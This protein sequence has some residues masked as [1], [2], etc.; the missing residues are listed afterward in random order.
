MASSINFEVNSV[1]LL[2]SN[3]NFFDR[4][5]I[6]FQCF[7]KHKS[8][9]EEIQIHKIKTGDTILLSDATFAQQY[10]GYFYHKSLRAENKTV[11]ILY[12]DS[13][14]SAKNIS[15]I[16]DGEGVRVV[17]IDVSSKSQVESR[18]LEC[19]V[20]ENTQD[21]FSLTAEELAHFFKCILIKG[22]GRVSDIVIELNKREGE[23]E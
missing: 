12:T 11:Q 3:A 2:L 17:D 8:D 22:K 14:T 16:I 20:K 13:Y 23:W 21:S 15:R 10:L 5:F 18:K 9:F 1:R 4:L 19:T 7:G 6:Y